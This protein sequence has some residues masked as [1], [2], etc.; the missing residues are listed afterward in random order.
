MRSPKSR[1]RDVLAMEITL[2]Y[3]KGYKRRPK[4]TIYFFIEVDDPI[5]CAITYLVAL[6]LANDAFEAP[7]LT[8]PKRVF[9]H[10]HEPSA[11]RYNPITEAALLYS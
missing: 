4:P 3:Y 1:E 2:A 6:A 7:S 5:F 9:K 10:K 8:T 11:D